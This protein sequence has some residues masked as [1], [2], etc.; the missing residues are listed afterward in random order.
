MAARRARGGR[1]EPTRLDQAKRGLVTLLFAALVLG[2]FS[3]RATGRLG[4]PD[5]VSAQ[6]ADAGGSLGRGADVKLRGVI[7]GRVADVARGPD[8][9]VRVTMAMAGGELEHVPANAVAR[10]LPATVFGTSYVDLTV[11]GR[12]AVDRL[13]AG[14][15]IPADRSQGTLELQQALDDI[16]TL[17]KALRPAQLNVT[18]GA[19]ATALDGRGEKIGEI[20]DGLDAL[21]RKVQPQVPLIRAD[22]TK[23]ATNLELVRQTA[24]QLLDGVQDS[25]GTLHTIVAQRAALGS[26]IT[27]GQSLLAEAD[28]FLGRIRP[29]LV[30]FIRDAAIVTDVYHDLRHQA[31]TDAFAVL[32]RVDAQLARIVR[33]GWV[34]NTLII[35]QDP[36]RYYTSQD[37]PRFGRAA[38]D[39][40]TGPARA[41]VGRMP[42]GGG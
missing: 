27:G 16:D 42:G 20:I 30:A 11:H 37:C 34:D 35:R 7:V 9:G 32:R 29:D 41:G 13:R 1:V 10:I 31:F 5:E 8:G 39:N 23:L 28:T 24:P 12:P 18:L 14:A 33:H 40:C 17:V 25:L 19:I 6:L 2:V 22:I 36:P 38:G 15:V 4:G 26:L 21:L 3:L